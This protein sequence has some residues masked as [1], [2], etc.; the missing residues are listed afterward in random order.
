M[1]KD[2]SNSTGDLDNEFQ[3]LTSL[4]SERG[5][6]FQESETS[7]NG[8]PQLKNSKST[9]GGKL[10]KFNVYNPLYQGKRPDGSSELLSVRN[11]DRLNKN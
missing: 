11:S 7:P 9:D 10:K 5:E 8:L 6:R 3:K 1:E 2:R 4:N